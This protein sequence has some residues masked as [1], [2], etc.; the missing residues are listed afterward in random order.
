M[1]E[2]E[3]ENNN[4]ASIKVIGVG[5]AGTNAVNRMIDSLFSSTGFLIH[6]QFIAAALHRK[7]T[8]T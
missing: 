7:L 6:I 5:G 8:F 4:F 2:F 1:L 3:M